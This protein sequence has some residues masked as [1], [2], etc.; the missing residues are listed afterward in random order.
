ML[1]VENNEVVE[2]VRDMQ[3]RYLLTGAANY[4]DASAVAAADW[5]SDKVVA[6]S[7]DLTLE[8]VDPAGI[9][10]NALQRHLQLVVTIRN[11]AQ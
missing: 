2:G 9:D 11:H 3:L 4:V 6:V 8:G 1:T 10:G 5:A 7:A